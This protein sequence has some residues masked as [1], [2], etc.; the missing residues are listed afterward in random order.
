MRTAL[1]FSA[2]DLALTR[3]AVSPMQEVV[4]S[5]RALAHSPV[6]TLHRR[7]ADQVRARPAATGLDRSRLAVMVPPTGHL[8]DFL[9]PAP[10]G[11]APALADELAAITATGAGQVR[12]DLDILAAEA[13]GRLPPV[14]ESLYR[15]P[16]G[17]L[18]RLAA[19][20]EAY[21]QLSLA[22]YWARIRALLEADVFHRSRQ[23]AEHG[24]A[25]MLDDLHETVRWDGTALRLERRHCAV[26]RLTAGAGLLLL[27]SAF[28][29]PQVLTRVLPPDPPQLSYPARGAATLWEPRPGG[30]PDALATV[31]GRSRARL[32]AE[33]DSPASTT[34][35]ARRTGLSAAGVSQ[36]LTAL[37]AAGLTSAHRAGHSVLYARTAVGDSLFEPSA[38]AFDPVPPPRRPGR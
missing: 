38:Q 30:A 25:R 11:F 6:P 23:A 24:T 14:L 32:L 4:T 10:T 26:T 5:L 28:A 13:G 31:L 35:L 8:P 3:F 7:W 12:A 19:E 21:W 18:P 17:Q 29:W 9:N 22:P 34:E 36:H 20:I 16:A 33:L 37:R 15:D 2:N 27:P 1:H